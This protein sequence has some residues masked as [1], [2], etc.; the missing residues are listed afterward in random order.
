MPNWTKEQ[1][2]AIYKSGTNIIVSAGAGSGK[3][4]VLSERVLQKV[5]SGI[6]VDKLLVLTFT[7]AAA[8]E[9]KE[10]IRKKLKQNNL[11]EQLTKLDGAY[12]T[13]FDAYALS[14]VKKYNYLL[15]ISK[16]ISVCEQSIM[17]IKKQEILEQVFLDMYDNSNFLTLIDDF[18]SKDDIEIKEYVL[19]INNKLDMI[20]N[21]EEYLNNYINNYYSDSFINDRINEY[22]DLLFNKISLINKELNSLEDYV[23]EDYYVKITELLNNLLFG[24]T[25]EDIKK[26]IVKLPNLP[27]G[28]DEEAKTIKT[29]IS[30]YLKEVT[31]M[32]SYDDINEIKESIL[33]TKKY[34]KVIIE[35][36]KRFDKE[37]SKYKYDNDLYE[38][39]DINKMAISLLEKYE[40]VRNE[41]KYNEIL[42]DE[43]QDTNDLQDLFISF[44]EN[45]NVYMVGDIKQS[46]YRFRNANP[47]L[48]KN[49]YDD[50]SNNNGGIKIDLNKNFRSREEVL[51]NINTIFELVMDNIIGGADYKESHKMIYGNLTYSNEGK[52]N[53]D[54]NLEI[55]NYEVN[56][57][58]K[59]EEIEIFTIAQD[60]KNKVQNKY[61]VFDKDS[62]NVRDIR[63][64]DIVILMDRAT[65]FE[66]YKKIFEYLSI[67][68]TLYKDESI[69]DNVDISII[70]NI[71]GFMITDN[72]VTK[73][74][75]FMSI[76]RSYLF[77]IDDNTIFNYITNEDFSY[78][79]N[80]VINTDNITPKDLVEYIIDKFE[81][82]NNIIKV[83]NI[84]SHIAIFDYLV[85]LA[86]NLTNMGYDVNDF[87]N[88]LEN[89]V[90]GK[91]DIKYSINHT[92]SNSVKIMT[93]HKSK[94]LE[95]HICYFSGLYAKFNISDLKEKFVYD[96]KLGI[97]TPIIDNGIR[98]TIYKDLLKHNYLMD[99]ISEKVRLFYVGLTR[100]QEK[101][102]IVMP[103]NNDEVELD[104]NVKMSYKSFADIINSVKSSL[105]LYI[106]KINLDDI[107]LTHD[108]NLIK[109]SNYKDKINI[110]KNKLDVIDINIPAEL[111]DKK[112][113]SK[114]NHKL[115]EK[116]DY[117]NIEFGKYIHSIFETID[118]KNPDYSNIDEFIK[119]KVS[120]FI[121]NNIFNGVLNIYKE[122]EFIYEENNTEMHGFID[123]LL[124]YDN[125][126]K[127]ID[128]KLK[129]IDDD[130]YIKQLL[131]YKKYIE[132]ITNKEVKIYL[133]SILDNKLI[134]KA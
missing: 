20:Y 25:Y 32:C 72:E 100:A 109:N 87:Y 48:F 92:D 23:D 102:I 65:N 43:Y 56:N 104:T 1:N 80:Y 105:S 6:D 90:N 3:T 18:C 29:R 4:A 13:T 9:M 69:N 75:S 73:K 112:H 21:K 41:L 98:N 127:I 37:I 123:L 31:N 27:K 57:E 70:K 114:E 68:I 77:S 113:F 121:T 51:N 34:V 115:Y 124:E 81:I 28:S 120:S 14:L 131:G 26:A 49:K 30:D 88:Y 117:D 50:Y 78:L 108:Y 107:G 119:E 55:L 11:L 59:K 85:N 16:N 106:K 12:I 82:Y 74:Y 58:Y 63:Y 39:I 15:N 38:F 86:D 128:Y 130:A 17:N 103:E 52:L 67:P 89:V 35:I 5:L 64:D 96:N 134:K 99:E 118:F 24:K 110:I 76:L 79:D 97:I 66:L 111:I 62:L 33:E 8:R 61:Q 91:V 47:N 125:E 71:I 44:I 133:Y 42:I 95:Y 60:I 129:N 45:N 84:D 93:I 7:N 19:N 132:Y 83:G 36:I 116:S 22:I 40:L 53:T 46:I 126:Y 94:G 54:C 122:Y 101:M 2:D 10:R